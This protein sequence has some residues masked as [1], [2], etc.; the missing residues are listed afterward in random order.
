MARKETAEILETVREGLFLLVKKKRIGTEFSKSL[1]DILRM[2][3]AP[4]A[5]FLPYLEAI[6]PRNVYEAAV[7]YI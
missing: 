4:G 6:A 2:E 5:S 1:P 3:I 7:D